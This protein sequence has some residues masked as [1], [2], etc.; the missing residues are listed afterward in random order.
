KRCHKFAA[1]GSSMDRR[2]VSGARSAVIRGYITAVRLF[3][4]ASRRAGPF[5]PRPLLA[6]ALDQTAILGQ[7]REE[8]VRLVCRQPTELRH[9]GSGDPS[10]SFDVLQHHLFL[11][12]RF[13]SPL[14]HVRGLV[15]KGSIRRSRK[16]PGASLLLATLFDE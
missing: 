5:V 14:A 6:A 9:L 8:P 11:L 16:V 1:Q 4:P 3:S 2:K 12:Q 15:A 10:V 7:A 13:E